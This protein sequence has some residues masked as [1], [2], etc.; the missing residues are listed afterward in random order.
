MAGFNQVQLLGNLTREPDFRGLPSG[1]QVCEFGIA[2]NTGRQTDKPYFGQIVTFGKTAELCRQYLSKGSAVFICGRL[3][4]NE[5]EDKKTGEKKSK[6]RVIADTVQFLSQRTQT[7]T[8]TQYQAPAQPQYQYQYQAPQAPQ[9][10]SFSGYSY[11]PPTPAP[12]PQA[13][14]PTPVDSRFAPPPAT[15]ELVQDDIPF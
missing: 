4:N 2:I 14:A 8:Q 11:Q 15:A 10:P 7:Q 9:A 3:E 5:W 12:A 13:T 1:M 6:T